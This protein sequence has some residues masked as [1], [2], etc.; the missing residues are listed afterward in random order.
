MTSWVRPNTATVYWIDVVAAETDTKK[1]QEIKEWALNCAPI[2][3]GGVLQ[4]RYDSVD[5]AI[6]ISAT[7]A[8]R[9]GD[10]S[11]FN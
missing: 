10:F 1:T 7:L 6:F 4:T 9:N 8:I 2:R 5:S 11:F 3:V